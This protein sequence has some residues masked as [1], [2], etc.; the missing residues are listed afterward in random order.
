MLGHRLDV[1]RIGSIVADLLADILDALCECG[2]GNKCAVPHLIKE[3]LFFHELTAPADQQEKHIEVFRVERHKLPAAPKLSVA[4]IDVYIAEAVPL[5]LR[6]GLLHRQRCTP[7]AEQ[8]SNKR[9]RAAGRLAV[10]LRLCGMT[11]A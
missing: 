11:R 2:V 6:T 5:D 3:A 9:S 4:G 7:T 8:K 10:S 1:A